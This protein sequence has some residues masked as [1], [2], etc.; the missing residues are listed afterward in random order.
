MSDNKENQIEHPFEMQKD[1]KGNFIP[2]DFVNAKITNPPVVPTVTQY[3]SGS[4][5][6]SEEV[7]AEPAGLDVRE[8]EAI[9][10]SESPQEV[11][12]AP[13]VVQPKAKYPPK[14]H[15]LRALREKSERLEAERAL[16]VQ[17]IEMYRRAS[18]GSQSTNPPRQ[19]MQSATPEEVEVPDINI[20]DDDLVEGKHLKQY[21]QQ[22]QRQLKASTQQYAQQA[23]AAQQSALEI[24][25]KNQYPDFDEV[26]NEGNLKDLRALHP[27]L[28]ASIYASQDL[29]NQAVTAYT[30]IKNLGIQH[31]E[32][33]MADK[34]RV[35]K[36]SVKP[37]PSSTAT[38][39]SS[40]PLGQAGNFSNGLT[41]ELQKQL[42]REMADA[43]SRR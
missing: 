6:S 3:A 27:E 14:E 33:Y 11:E 29:R 18:S 35:K 21:V 17:E 2:P 12:E 10:Q 13:S 9:E 31:E 4:S 28:A 22:I 23:A 30:M 25:I 5:V 15:N 1:E 40:S 16:M 8:E 7:V 43:R 26:V 39:T 34:E 38:T 32:N 41:P 20:G 19:A 42:L 24:Q 37:R 36:N